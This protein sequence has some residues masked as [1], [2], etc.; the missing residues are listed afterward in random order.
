MRASIKPRRTAVRER[1]VDVYLAAVL[2]GSLPTLTA[3]AQ[4]GISWVVGALLTALFLAFA[5]R[6]LP[7]RSRASL[8]GAGPR[9][10]I[11]LAV[12][13]C[14]LTYILAPVIGSLLVG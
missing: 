1:G 4:V 6:F 14:T 5:V 13:A 9:G 11:L 7:A 3:V 10:F 2:L 8:R 12:F